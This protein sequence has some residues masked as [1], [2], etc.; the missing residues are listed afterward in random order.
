MLLTARFYSNLA[1]SIATVLAARSRI[2]AANKVENIDHCT[3]VATHL[4]LPNMSRICA[5]L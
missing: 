1:A 5:M 3:R 2:T 4:G